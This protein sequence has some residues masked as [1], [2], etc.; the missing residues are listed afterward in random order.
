ML[1]ASRLA[2]FM[3]QRQQLPGAISKVSARARVPANAIIIFSI[4]ASGLIATGRIMLLA[5]LYAF[6][7]VLAY[8]TAHA[9]II[10]LRVK[11]PNLPRPFK[12]PWNIHIR[13]REIPVTAII[14]GLA[15][16][17]TWF[18][19]VYTH[20]IGRIVGFAW[21]GIGLLVYYIY[22][23]RKRKLAAGGSG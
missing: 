4:I 13:G 3:G 15:T 22:R 20:E 5:D 6:G 16:F 1:G 8:T 10:A 12:I 2:Y 23:R 17:V 14:G 21:L 7:A 18:I 11:E 19:V 9:S